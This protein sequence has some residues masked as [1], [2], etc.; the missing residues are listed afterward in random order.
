[1]KLGDLEKWE[2]SPEEEKRLQQPSGKKCRCGRE[3]SVGE[4]E[5]SDICSECYYRAFEEQAF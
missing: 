4:A 1:M 2:V 3:M 5:C